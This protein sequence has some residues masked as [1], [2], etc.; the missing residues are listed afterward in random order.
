M[1]KGCFMKNIFKLIGFIALAAVI[2]FGVIACGG[3]D[4]G[5]N[6]AALSAKIDEAYAEKDSVVVAEY[7]GEVSVG[8]KWVTEAVMEVFENAIDAAELIRDTA[9]SQDIVEIAVA[10]LDAAIDVFIDAKED[11]LNQLHIID[12]SQAISYAELIAAQVFVAATDADAPYGAYWVTQA[13]MNA[14]LAAIAAAKTARSSATDQDEIDDALETLEGAVEVFGDIVIDNGP[15]KKTTDFT[16]EQVTALIALANADKTDVLTSSEDGDDIS[17]LVYWASSDDIAAFTAAITALQNASGQT[18]IDTAYL[19]LIQARMEFLGAKQYG[20]TPDK[21]NLEYRIDFIN[22]AKSTVVTAANVEAAPYGSLWATAAQKAEINQAIADAITVYN[23]PHATAKQVNS[24]LEEL[25]TVYYAFLNVVYSTNGP[26][27]DISSAFAHA[28]QLTANEDASD[29]ISDSVT[30]FWYKFNVIQ[31]NEYKIS[32]SDRRVYIDVLYSDETE[33]LSTNVGS[34]SSVTFIAGKDDTVYV[35]ISLYSSYGSVKIKYENLGNPFEK[36]VLLPVDTEVSGEFTETVKEVWYKFSVNAGTMYDVW[37]YDDGPGKV[38][39][40]FAAIYSNAAEI[41]NEDRDNA[42]VGFLATKTDTVYLKVSPL[43]VSITGSFSVK[44]N[45]TGTVT[46][47]IANTEVPGTVGGTVEEVWYSFTTAAGQLYQLW[48]YDGTDNS[49]PTNAV[50]EVYTSD[51]TRKIYTTANNRSEGIITQTADTIYI[52][53]SNSSAIDF[54]IKYNALTPTPLTA[55][56]EVSGSV[57]NV[58][59]HWYSF[60]VTAGQVYQVWL[61]NDSGDAAHIR[62]NA[63]YSD[64]TEVFREYMSSTSKTFAAAKGGTVYLKVFDYY[65]SVT[66]FKLKC[67]HLVVEVL[68]PPANIRASFASYASPSSPSNRVLWNAVELAKGYNV[69]RSSNNVS[70]TKISGPSLVTSS[71]F[72]DYNMTFG[73]TYYYKVSTVNLIDQEGAQSEAVTVPGIRVHT[74]PAQNT[75]IIGEI[76]GAISSNADWY[77]L[78]VTKNTSYYFWC[79]GD[80]LQMMVYSPTDWGSNSSYPPNGEAVIPGADGTLY[81]KVTSYSGVQTYS[82][83]YNTTGIKPLVPPVPSARSSYPWEIYFDWSNVE[84]A[85]SYIVY[86]SASEDTGYT[87]VTEV[88]LADPRSYTDTTVTFGQTYYYKISSKR[89]SEE[90]AQSDAISVKAGGSAVHVTTMDQWQTMRQLDNRGP[91]L[92]YAL[93]V[94][95]GTPHRVYE[96][97]NKSS[98]FWDVNIDVYNTNGTTLISMQRD[99]TNSFSPTGSIVFV[100]IYGSRATDSNN[101]CWS[102][103]AYNTGNTAPTGP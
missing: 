25:E 13:D 19:A 51:M 10:V 42:S 41:F 26:G 11:G 100:R 77:S 37:L 85:E 28:T 65:S 66:N 78:S 62:L 70:F 80:Y 83:L 4:N 17:P 34:G 16:P 6:T 69:Y 12:L 2:G 64:M 59:E 55:N 89:G 87:Q 74:M 50:L 73:Q 91:D 36:A 54:K 20:T 96:S 30:R 14:F 103:I 57:N 38:D 22:K 68:G 101:T 21:G 90:S 40:R 9:L 63:Y 43:N 52:K 99:T 53:I 29:I 94:T 18:A 24:I 102:Q 45:V 81:I 67:N 60:T 58:T 33:I 76:D 97:N 71:S 31:G 61:S 75:P 49:K 79:D 15:G 98:S 95:A 44:Y 46:Q 5:V 86:R 3:G 47:L 27:K 84:E 32:I 93:N 35:T 92:W 39:S 8:Q 82:L 72:E 56:T 23:D 7:A 48:L 1:Q 88:S